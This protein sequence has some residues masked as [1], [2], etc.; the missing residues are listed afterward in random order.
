MAGDKPSTSRAAEARETRKGLACGLGTYLT[1]GLAPAYYRLLYEVSPIQVLAHRVFWSVLLLL[2]LMRYRGLWGDVGRALRSK[3]TMVRLVLSTAMI[4]TNWFVFIY[5][6]TIHE[7]VQTSLGYF[8]NPLVVVLL[9][10]FVL[11]ER[12]RAWQIVS[13]GLGAAAV[14]ILTIAQGKLPVISLILAFSF[15]FYG[16]LRKTVNAS[17]LVG[18][19]IETMLLLPLAVAMIIWHET[20]GVRWS[21]GTYALLPCSGVLT[22]IPLLW[23]ANAAKR[24]RLSTIGL[25]QYV[26]PM[27]SFV[28]A[29]LFFHEP[30]TWVQKIAFP[31][32]WIALLIYSADAFRA[33]R[34]SSKRAVADEEPVLTDL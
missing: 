2:P 21:A 10:V 23:F 7:V 13:L 5:A 15:A 19:F 27:C 25:L 22:A 14:I 18:L 1:W 12:L 24:L 16:F 26:T 32:I 8:I 29:V 20:A 28:L 6:V 34:D 11:K 9:G 17:P 4:A 3:R 31:M 33:M 30:F